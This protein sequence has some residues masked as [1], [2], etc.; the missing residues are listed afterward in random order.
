MPPFYCELKASDIGAYLY[1]IRDDSVRPRNFLDVDNED[2]IEV[3]LT[4]REGYFLHEFIDSD[5]P[6]RPIID[7]DLPVAI[8]TELI[9]KKLSE[10]LQGKDIIDNIA[11]KR[12]FSLRIVGTPKFIEETG[13]HV[14]VKKAINSKDRTIFDFMIRPSNDESKVIKS[15]LLVVSE[16]EVK[17]CN[18]IN[19][20]ITEIEFKLVEKL[21]E[22]TSIEGFNLSFSSE[23]SPDVFSLKRIA[24]SYCSLCDQEYI[25]EK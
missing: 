25:N 20:E 21:L 17:R 4:D 3:I 1:K 23:Q 18:D 19:S 9:C 11:N 7:F 2:G 22:E 12:S 14:C 16:P 10:G 15:S 13:E 24:P 5:E 6:L 8:F